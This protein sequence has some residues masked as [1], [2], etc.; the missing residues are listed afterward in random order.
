MVIFHVKSKCNIGTEFLLEFPVTLID[1]NINIDV[2]DDLS[3]QSNVEKIRIEFSD[4][5]S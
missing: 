1:E 3:E 5:Y 4:I 2:V